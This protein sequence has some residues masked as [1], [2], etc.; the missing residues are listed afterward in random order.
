[1]QGSGESAGAR[2]EGAGKPRVAI[3]EDFALIQ[4]SIRKVLDG[5]CEVVAA[6]DDE[7][8]ALA[9][10]A[11]WQPDIVTLDVSLPGMGGFA[12]A[13]ELS[14]RA[15]LTRVVFVTAHSQE[16]YA[17]RA[18]EAGA[19]GYVIKG[20]MQ[21]ELPAAVRSVMSG[22]RFVSPLLRGFEPPT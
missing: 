12:L 1:M 19:K 6:V 21:T 3:V 5:H 16:G 17:E 11:E 15:P 20:A 2:I 22:G 13:E 8:G 7:A 10:V 9:A 14:R 4:E 18:F